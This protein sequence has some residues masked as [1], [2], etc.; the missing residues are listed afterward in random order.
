ML[1]PI[2]YGYKE[3]LR[4]PRKIADAL[5]CA[6]HWPGSGYRYDS[7]H[8]IINWGSGDPIGVPQEAKI[9]NKYSAV[10]RSVRKDESFRLFG[11]H[12]VTIPD[13]TQRIQEAVNW[14]RE[15]E[16]VF[17]R[18][19]LNGENGQGIVLAKNEEQLV[20]A[21]LY[22]KYVKNRDEF[23]VHVFKGSPI[24]WTKKILCPEAP[25]DAQ[26]H[27]KSGDNWC[28]G[29]AD[30][31]PETCKEQAIKATTALGLDFAA[32]DIGMNYHRNKAYVFETNTAPGAFG[33]ITLAKYVEAIRRELEV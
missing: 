15:G 9:L 12:G 33:P 7:N 13:I 8:L 18:Q 20:H 4:T 25:A 32:V 3:S 2:I 24:F 29:R 26:Y 31:I 23:R 11:Q 22:T 27:I 6:R 14:I 1:T 21:N 28:M 10:M 19:S 16:I 30:T 5:P 17:C